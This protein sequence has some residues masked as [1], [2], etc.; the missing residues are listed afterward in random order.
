[1]TDPDGPMPRWVYWRRRAVAAAGSVAVLLVLAG[2]LGLLHE[3]DQ[4]GARGAAQQSSVPPA[5]TTGPASA[6]SSST[7]A[8]PSG[9]PVSGSVPPPS[10]AS[11]PSGPPSQQAAPPPPPPPPPGPPP[12]CAD[13]A[14]RLTAVADQR[15]YRAGQRP[16]FRIVLLNAGPVACVRDVSR[17]LRELVVT[18]VDR[19]ARL[20]S[21]NDCYSDDTHEARVLRPGE[22]LDYEVTWARRTSAPGCPSGRDTV[23]PGDYLLV[24]RLGGLT[25]PPAVFRLA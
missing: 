23:R 3:H 16:G 9:V 13:A 20:W 6:P 1:M 2:L 19:R 4:S 7:S 14:M 24:A 17:P 22:R 25:S 18:T 15:V 12:P 21:S 10:G 5:P 8:T 11:L